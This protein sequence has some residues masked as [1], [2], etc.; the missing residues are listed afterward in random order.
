MPVTYSQSG[1]MMALQTPLGADKLLLETLTGVEALSELFRFEL[2]VLC[3]T[4][5]SWAFDQLLGQSVTVQLE[6]PGGSMRAINGIVSRI[7]QADRVPGALG[8]E[9]FVRYVLEV[10]P[11]LWL[12]SLNQNTRTFQ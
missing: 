5:D 1:R 4:T 10:V 11:K 7:G 3:L 9:T 12:L 6:Q 8:E 2:T